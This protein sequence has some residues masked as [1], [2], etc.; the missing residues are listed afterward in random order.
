MTSREPS[1]RRERILAA[2]ES[3][4]AAHG[5][6]GARVERIALVAGVNKQLLFHYFGSKA[7]LYQAVIDTVA[8]R[9]SLRTPST[10]TPAERIR[11]VLAAI[12]PA[13]RSLG[14]VLP[15]DFSRRATGAVREILE[16][17]QRR[18]YVRD[19]VDPGTIAQLVVA[20]AAGWG[21]ASAVAHSPADAAAGFSRLVGAVIADYCAWR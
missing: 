20:A 8:G 4:F 7:G 16:D 2:A 3:E 12:L 13:Y 21:S 11:G 19:D 15:S 6:A 9:L 1:P 5:L 14:H 17:G 18:G 10:Q